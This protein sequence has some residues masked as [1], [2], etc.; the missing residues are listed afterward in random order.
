MEFNELF[1]YEGTEM[2]ICGR[3]F[4]F[5]IEDDLGGEWAIFSDGEYTYAEL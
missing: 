5:S 1:A 2:E 3:T 4:K